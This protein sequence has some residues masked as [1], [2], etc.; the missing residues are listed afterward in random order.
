MIQLPAKKQIASI[1]I[2]TQKTFT[3]ACP[4]ELPVPEGDQIVP[5]LNKQA[6]FAQY[7]IGSKEAHHP[8]AKWIAQDA[9]EQ[10][11]PVAGENMDVKWVAHSIVG[12]KGHEMLEGLPKIIDY[13]FFIWEGIELDMHPY[14]ICY[15][16]FKEKLST[17]VIEFLQNRH[18]D[19]VI[20]GGLAT[21]YCVKVS[22]LQLLKAGFNVIVNLSACRGIAA[23][24]TLAAIEQMQ[25]AGALLIPDHHALK[26]N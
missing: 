18:V 15:H 20:V 11:Q 14:G 7:R 24:T 9:T 22:V 4:D 23:D 12:S 19:T 16:D 2:H 25:T 5:E 26:G 1:E 21:D 8:Q 13:D 10:L 6:E 17:G 3:P